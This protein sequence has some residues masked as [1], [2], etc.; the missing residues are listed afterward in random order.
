MGITRAQIAR[1]LLAKGG[2][3]G[4]TTFQLARK[5]PDGKKPGYFG[6][7]A[8]EGG[9]ESDFGQDTYSTS[10]VD[11]GGVS[12]GTDQQ[13]ADTRAAIEART[14]KETLGQKI[15]NQLKNISKFSP[16]L[17][18]F[19]GI[20]NLFDKFQNLRGFNPDGTRR[21]QAQ[22]EQARR[23]RINQNR[24]SNILGRDAPFTLQTLE[25]LAKLGYTG[26]L[27]K[28]LIG[29]TNITRSGTSDQNFPDRVE[30]IVSQA[31]EEYRF[32]DAMANLNLQRGVP[33]DQVFSTRTATGERTNPAIEGFKGFF[34]I[35]EGVKDYE[36]LTGNRPE[37]EKALREGVFDAIKQDALFRSSPNFKGERFTIPETLQIGYDD[38]KGK[39]GATT[40]SAYGAPGL[41]G[42]LTGAGNQ[43]KGMY[44]A[45]TGDP[46]SILNTTLGR[47]T[48]SLDP[49]AKDPAAIQDTYNFGT[50]LDDVASKFGGGAYKQD[51]ALPEDFSKQVYDIY[52]QTFDK[53]RQV[54]NT[55]ID[56]QIAS[57]YR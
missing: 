14:P 46:N 47:S 28:S 8:G 53:A 26:P 45:L 57:L 37:V 16:S 12:G 40:A 41:Q 34:G 36:G 17:N 54:Q 44:A 5:R 25:N 30:G 6:P 9:M 2:K 21:T 31:P 35:G 24:I 27:D 18:I 20:G 10:D 13:F 50:F 32:T 38:F 51:I 43:A 19:K 15:V 29:S 49:A 11:F 4:N 33:R 1:Q 7:D 52:N 56:Q 39:G 3:I 23:D 48:L 55:G 22:F 42:F